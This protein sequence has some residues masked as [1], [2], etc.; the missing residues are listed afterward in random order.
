MQARLRRLEPFVLLLLA[1]IAQ[2]VGAAPFPEPYD[3]DPP[4]HV[5][6]S[7]AAAAA[8]FR[9]PE[10]FHV[11]VFAAEPDVRQPIA[12]TTDPRGRLWVVENF[13]YA[14]AKAG[15]AT[16]L[17][18]RI[19]IFA[20]T[21]HDGRFDQRTVF[22]DQGKLV[23]SAEPGPG[24]VY[25][26]APP[27]LLFI[28]D[29]NG[30]DIPDGEPEVL[31]DGFNTTTG[32]RHT[33]ANGLKWGPDG[34]LWGRVG[35]SSTAKAGRPGAPDS[36][37]ILMAGGIWRYHP[38]RRV[39]EAVAQGTTNPWGLDW[40][41]LGEP[42]F[43]N[44]VI[45]HLW[46]A[47]PGAHFQRMYGE[48]PDPHSYDLIAQHADH[49]HFDTGAGWTKSRAALDG[50]SFAS[51]SDSLGGGHAH[52]GLLFYLGTNWPGQYRDRL[53]TINLHGRRANQERIQREGLG[54]VGRH[55]PD[56]FSVGDP[57]FRGLD[58]VQGPDGGVFVTDWSDTGECHD[59]DGIHRG[60]GR[61]YKITYGT[62]P[63]PAIPDLNAL[64]DSALV[65]L[66]ADPNEWLSRQSRQVLVNR[67][68][69]GKASGVVS[70]LE[71]EF[72]RQRKTPG[73]LRA[74]WA[75]H[76]V[77]GARPEWL[78]ERLSNHTKD[79]N[80]YIRS[81]AVRLLA[82]DVWPRGARQPSPAI[83]ART[84]D[85]FLNL[86]RT[87]P[88]NS[89]VRLYLASA[90]QHLPL[91]ARAS[92]ASALLQDSG[93]GTDHNQGFLIWYGI[94]DLVAA[95]PD[96]AVDLA[97]S[98]K[99]PLIRKNVA[100]WLAEDIE[101]NPTALDQLLTRATPSPPEDQQDIVRGM[102]EALKGWRRAP[103]PPSWSRFA[104]AAS[105]TGDAAHRDRVRDLTILFGDG[106]ALEDLRALVLNDTV[107]ALN[108]RAALRTLIESRA[109][110]L[111][112]LLR[113]LSNDPILRTQALVA[114]IQSGDAEAARTAAG[115]YPW[116]DATDRAAVLA[117]LASRP[118]TAGIL[119]D[120][121]VARQV[122]KGDVTPFL[123]RQIAGL[124]DA[125]LS[126]RLSEVWG[127]VR[128]SDASRRSTVDRF[129]KQMT[130][131]HLTGAHL[132]KGRL[133]FSQLCAPCHRLYGEGADVGPD[134]TGSGR[135]QL[136]YLLE[137]LADP[138]AVV[139]ADYRMVAINLK[140][141][142]VLNGILR[143]QTD[144]IVTL[145]TQ[146]ELT[147]LERSEIASMEPSG[148]SMM[149]EG[150]LESLS[151]DQARDLLAY[152]M[153]P[154]QVALPASP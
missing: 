59:Q 94:E 45:G 114:L 135:S 107:P 153:S 19:L 108:R 5:P 4:D 133:V 49:F 24:G 55:E 69:A 143:K 129:R 40:N 126:N 73:R 117:A 60:S 62:P 35:I 83:Q 97:I 44:T 116:L 99:V 6:T 89:I 71:V 101:K 38:G 122:P 14:D 115:R 68:P 93:S 91:D 29:R 110:N 134:L 105:T 64:D 118:A 32:S 48:D 13:T 52:S 154:K 37:R 86:A 16:N 106:R 104:A 43:I 145:Q 46:H 12:L 152:L 7:A 147:P 100:R 148:Q 2:A 10:G 27:H 81:W 17:S 36:E 39:V 61:I 87:E 1:G 34:W 98:G 57:W 139:P 128:T 125:A 146:G 79:A 76:A 3:T 78:L 90:L 131:E 53:F 102:T 92:L 142:R 95:R 77:G 136:D 66:V 51:G 41:E 63:A 8:S 74:I 119:L 140:D 112:P 54:F 65:A 111:E 137:N 28:P 103:A 123:A 121:I 47:I 9:L 15:F 56:L 82:D 130:T 127:S 70:Q 58:L 25:V 132:P 33:F 124:N 113:Q 75:L 109:P 23:T 50:S 144:R 85:T 80:E 22:W 84:V 88:S 151:P 11:S 72:G 141:G 26:M 31:L 96:T 30:D 18:D 120:G 67:R 150:M 149:P 42:F 21:N 138:S 20:D